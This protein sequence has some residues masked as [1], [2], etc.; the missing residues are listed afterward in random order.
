MKY[1]KFFE[2]GIFHFLCL[3]SNFLKYKRFFRVPVF[4]NIRK[5]FFWENIRN[6]LTFVPESSISWN[7]K[8]YKNF[9]YFST[10]GLKG[11]P[12]T[13]FCKTFYRR[14][15]PMFWLCLG[16]W[17]YQ[18]SKYAASSKYSRVLNIPFPKY[19]KVLFPEN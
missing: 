4:W 13:Y 5:A 11:A 16:F 17:V 9:F 18:G 7:I 10:L 12:G 14:Y 8:K 3:E 6:F 1:K 15:L 19:K 2:G